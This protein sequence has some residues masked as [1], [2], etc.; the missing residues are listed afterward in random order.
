[1]QVS[2]S[3][4]MCSLKD[5]SVYVECDRLCRT[6]RLTTL[7][8]MAARVVV[9]KDYRYGTN[10]PWTQAAK[11][12]NPPGKKRR[13][14]FVEPIAQEDWSVLKGDAVSSILSPFTL[15]NTTI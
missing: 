10:R 5:S 15:T 9:P 8:S 6:M 4:A 13:K 3:T 7:L 1:M 12:L 14:V 2:V 11:R